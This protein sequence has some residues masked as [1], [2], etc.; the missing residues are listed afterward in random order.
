MKKGEEDVILPKGEPARDPKEKER[1]KKSMEERLRRITQEFKEGFEIIRNYPKSVSFFGSARASEDEPYYDKARDLAR[2][3][4]NLGYAI[5]TGGG[6]GV[7]EAANRGA[8]EA[9]GH[10]VGLNIELPQEQSI[11]EYVTK[12]LEFH[13]FFSR[14]MILSFS[15]EAYVFFP[16]GFGTLDEFFEII[17]LIQTRKIPSV[18]VICVEKDYWEPLDKHIKSIL[19]NKFH[20]V[21]PGDE[22]I[23]KICDNFETAVDIIK[24]A[25]IR[26]E[27]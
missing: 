2:E 11:N 7:M 20:T 22:N 17:T 15:A 23:Y 12:H 25:P 18:P 5:I 10:S 14:K 1:I 27:D 19:L 8:H 26:R 13:Y 6:F 16:G 21:S 4:S 3:L 24:N 9:G